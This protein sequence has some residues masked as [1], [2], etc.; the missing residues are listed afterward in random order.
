MRPRLVVLDGHSLNP[1]DLDWSLLD[2]LGTCSIYPRTAP[3]D[4]LARAEGADILLTNKVVLDRPAIAAL[5]AL[6]Y[7]GVLATGY[8]VVDLAAASERGIVVTNVPAYST[9]SVAQMVFALLLEMTQQ[10]GHH[11]ALVRQGR[12]SASPDFSFWDR[13]LVELDGRILGLVGFGAIGQ[14]VAA[15]GR[16]FGMTVVVHTAHPERHAAEAQRLGVRFS[17]LDE[18]FAVA[19]VL[20]LHCPLTAA[21]RHLVDARRLSLMQ[22]TAYLINTGRGPLVDEEA[23]AR[24]LREKRLAGAGLDVLAAEPPAADNPLTAAPDCFV[25]PHIAW[26]TRAARQRLLDAAAGNIRA[27]LAG[28]P[29]NVVNP[30]PL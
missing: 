23:L 1:G 3:A 26:A 21:T 22:P 9:A 12:W 25:T 20:S 5:P 7:I 2:D 30:Q 28:Q 16:A 14:R 29:R 4:L 18:L 10:V 13:P 24:A 11:A 8:N 19:D 6:R 27:F 15:I 17:P